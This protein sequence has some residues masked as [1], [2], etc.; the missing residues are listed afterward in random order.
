MAGNRNTDQVTTGDMTHKTH[1]LSKLL[2]RLVILVAGVAGDGLF[3]VADPTA[4]PQLPDA[5]RRLD[6]ERVEI[7]TQQQATAEAAAAI[8]REASELERRR[9]ELLRELDAEAATIAAKE[10]ANQ[11]QATTQAETLAAR[12]AEIEHVLR[13]GGKWVSFTDE[14]APLLR[15]RCVACHSSREPGG[16]HVLTNYAGLFSQGANGPAVTAGDPASLLCEAVANGSMPQDGEPLSPAEVD[17]IQRWVALGARLDA[18]A[19][20]T[21][22][23]VRIMPRPTQPSPPAHYA[24]ALP[25]SAL[26][27]D[28]S[29]TRLL[30]A[31]YH[32]VL[33]WSVRTDAEDGGEARMVANLA[34][35]INDFT[36]RV[37]GLAFS[38]DGQRV[39]VAAGTPGVI[40]EVS[41]LE[42][43]SSAE[44]GSGITA[45]RSLGLGDDGFLSVAFSADGSRLAAAGADMTL[46]LYD[47]ATGE[48]L[49]E[50][51]DHAD[52][53]Q[54]V[55]FSPSGKKIVSV[56]RDSTAKVVDIPSGKLLTTFN[57]HSEPVTVACWIDEETVA[58]GGA[59]GAVRIWRAENGKELRTI[60]GGQGG[61]EGLCLLSDGRLAV[62][63][64]A[65]RVRLHAV[66]DGKLLQEVATV[67][68][69]IATLTASSDSRLLAVGCLDGTITLLS[70]DG[71]R[72]PVTW[73]AAP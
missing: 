38:V 64:G 8:R 15:A 46:R 68:S 26:A 37:H 51:S 23:L 20:A 40:G 44:S 17:V 48:Q 24:A 70:L 58:T 6:A 34:T 65:G 59:D 5:V 49:A 63:E 39:A 1:V 55:A 3:A 35:R 60:V 45:R 28:A 16:G 61:V 31:G 9:Q 41:L 14:I 25:V 7:E 33:S 53:V 42:V 21:A 30:S 57:G 13:A 29:G 36:E 2:V 11:E 67:E 62:A 10:K 66:A 69:R 4:L 73:Q 12:A 54:A 56:S 32:E 22:A 72:A 47:V 19:D 71:S 27:F 52:W 18:G 43:P 50:R